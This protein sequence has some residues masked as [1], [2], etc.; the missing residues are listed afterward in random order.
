MG[1]GNW[2]G[3]EKRTGMGTAVGQNW[4]ET[5]MGTWMETGMGQNWR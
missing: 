1:M 3:T 2:M 5:G 4:D